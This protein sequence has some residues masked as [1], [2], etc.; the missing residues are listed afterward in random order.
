MVAARSTRQVPPFVQ[1]VHSDT[2]SRHLTDDGNQPVEQRS[3][4]E[5]DGVADPQDRSGSGSYGV[6]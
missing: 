6:T 5:V 4:E 2:L 1:V 3:G